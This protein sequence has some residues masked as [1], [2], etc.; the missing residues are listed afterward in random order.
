MHIWEEGII[1]IYTGGSGVSADIGEGIIADME[2]IGGLVHI[3]R[4]W[5][6]WPI[7]KR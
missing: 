3:W 2:Y 5:E 7:R 1:S 6:Y 4:I